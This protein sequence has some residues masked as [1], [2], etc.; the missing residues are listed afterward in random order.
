[1]VKEGTYIAETIYVPILCQKVE[2]KKSIIL[3]EI[4]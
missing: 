3:L 2:Y 1:M 4:T